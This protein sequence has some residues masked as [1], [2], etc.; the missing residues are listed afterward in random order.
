MTQ[1]TNSN[2]AQLFRSRPNTF[3]QKFF[4][5]AAQTAPILP[6]DSTFPSYSIIDIEG[7]TVQ[8]GVGILI[9][10]GVYRVKFTP[11][12]AALLST[13]EKRWSIE[14]TMVDVANSQFSFTQQFDVID[15][16]VAQDEGHAQSL[17]ALTDRAFNISIKWPTLPYGLRLDVSGVGGTSGPVTNQT[18]NNKDIGVVDAPDGQKLFC[19]EITAKN[20]QAVGTVKPISL[21]AN[22]NY[23]ALWELIETQGSTPEYLTQRIDV[24][25]LHMVSLF[26]SLR[27]LI[28]KVQLKTGRIQSYEDAEINEYLLRGKDL[29]NAI[30]PFTAWT[31]GASSP[32]FVMSAH[33]M[34]AAFWYGLN[35]QHMMETYLQF[36]FAGSQTS[37]TLDRTA[38][39][40]SALTR[41]YEVW[42]SQVLAA[43]TAIFR[44]TSSVGSVSTRPTSR[45]G[46]HDRIYKFDSTTGFD[47]AGNLPGLLEGMGLLL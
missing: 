35:A 6:L 3:E 21:V 15:E 25:D 4:S 14:W 9:E 41:A 27:M 37:I 29:I 43:K 5:D 1:L 24:V 10:P 46:F 13:P 45:Y 31:L 44:R 8:A 20:E 11:A 23:V 32:I 38:G 18:L 30:H 12:A 28:D 36:D 33:L 40:D 17:L 47:S 22:N 42:T 39:I 34:L 26:P 16:V 19:Y 7:T 2:L